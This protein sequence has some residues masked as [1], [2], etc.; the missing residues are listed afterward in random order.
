MGIR[1]RRET[2]GLIPNISKLFE[3]PG[4]AGPSQY[5][6]EGFCDPADKSEKQI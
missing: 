6:P 4:G 5:R 3:D 2:I 1:T